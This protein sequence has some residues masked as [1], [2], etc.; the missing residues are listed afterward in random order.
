ML[1]FYVFRFLNLKKKR[2]KKFWFSVELN[3]VYKITT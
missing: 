2:F 3:T 1:R